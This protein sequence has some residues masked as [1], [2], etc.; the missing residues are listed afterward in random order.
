[1]GLFDRL[2]GVKRPEEGAPVL[3]RDEVLR[4]L[5]ALAGEQVPFV[6]APS[7]DSSV[8]LEVTWRIV[9][10]QWYEVF[11]KAGLE[12]SHTILLGLD[13]AEHEV[14]AL[15]VAYQVSWRA[16]LPQLRLSAEK[17]QGRT[18]GGKSF[19]AGYAFTGV[20]PLNWGQAYSYRF[21]VSEMKD[22]VTSVVTRAGWSYVPVMTRGALRAS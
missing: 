13:E 4:R 20:D 12:K 16:G 2:K 21:D 7:A 19:G 5:Q 1:V 11:A 8:D 18:F 9:D 10:A 3:G 17:F 6:V 15:E 22:P 14:H